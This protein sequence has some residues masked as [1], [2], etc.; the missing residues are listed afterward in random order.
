MK[1]PVSVPGFADAGRSS[2]AGRRGQFPWTVSRQKWNKSAS[3]VHWK[4]FGKALSG[5]KHEADTRAD[6]TLYGCVPQN[7]EFVSTFLLSF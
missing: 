4:T 3:S 7:S 6:A 2:R 5:R 1:L